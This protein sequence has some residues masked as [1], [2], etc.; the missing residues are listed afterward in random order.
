[1]QMDN[2]KQIGEIIPLAQT[3]IEKWKPLESGD[4]AF[5]K[6]VTKETKVANE[7]TENIDQLFRYLFTIIGLRVANYPND[8]ETLFLHQYLIDVFPG[9]SLNEIKLAFRKAANGELNL[10]P[11][12]VDCFQNFSPVYLSRIMNAYRQWASEKFR[13][14]EKYIPPSEADQKL[15]EGP[16]K[17][18]RHWGKIIEDEYQHYLSF[19]KEHC[20]FWPVQI[21]NQLVVD[22]FIDDELWR[23]AMPVI[24]KKEIENLVKQRVA[25]EVRV[26]PNSEKNKRVEFA[27]SI[28]QTNIQTIEKKIEGYRNGE[29]DG[30]IE[31]AA[32]QYCILQFFMLKKKNMVQHIYQKQD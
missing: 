22:D 25:L 10:K 1:M 13:S 29:H 5:L 28:N 2:I 17:D 24:R 12:E 9:H 6:M 19:G 15:L 23:K 7:T 27:Q 30:E 21:Y 20:R 4:S 14:L 16:R 32:K 8:L 31:L 26:F 3:V 11:E 18:D